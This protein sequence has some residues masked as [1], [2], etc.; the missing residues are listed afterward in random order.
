MKKKSG[1]LKIH[2]GKSPNFVLWKHKR[3]ALLL[4]LFLFSGLHSFSQD[5]AAK[6]HFGH[7]AGLD[8]MTNPPTIIPNVAIY[9]IEGSASISDAAGNTLF[10]TDG[11]TVYNK[12]NLIM[13]NGTGLFGN[14]STTQG[15]LI[16]K[17][18]GN[19][20]I[21]Y[22][23][24]Q[25]ELNG[26]KGLCYSLVDMSQGSGLG[27]VT[28]KNVLLHTPSCEKLAAVKHCNGVDVWVVSHDFGTNAFRSY[29]ITAAGINTTSPAIS[30]IGPV[31]THSITT[32]GQMKISPDGKKL[33]FVIHDI[34]SLNYNPTSRPVEIFDFDAATGTVSNQM[35]LQNFLGTYGCEFSPDGTKFYVSISQSFGSIFSP[36]PI[37]Y[38]FQWDLCA[39]SATAVAN[40]IY[41]IT[42]PSGTGKANQMQLARDGKIYIAKSF[43]NLATINAPNLAGAACDYSNSSVTFSLPAIGTLGL[44]N[45]MASL[46]KPA[47][48]PFTYST[49]CNNVNFFSPV[50][51][52]TVAS[53]CS[54][55]A[56]PIVSTS[57]NFGEPG[58]AA[59]NTSN[60]ANPTHSYSA[61]G[62]YTV[63]L[64]LNYA[65]G[66]D[67]ILLP[68]TIAG[69]SFSIAGLSTVCPKD[70]R[71]YTASGASSYSWSTGATTPTVALTTSV[72]TTYTVTAFGPGPNPC[73]MVTTFLV[74]V[75]KCTSIEPEEASG[76]FFKVYPNPTNGIL[77]IETDKEV[78]VVIENALGQI[79]LDSSYGSGSHKLDINTYKDGI[80]F[81][82]STS[83]SSSKIIRL[84]KT[85]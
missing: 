13:I 32:V 82:K 23:F 16:V 84:V 49:T 60:L 7:Y 36:T 59:T 76:T 77:N 72:T 73:K 2:T 50:P 57:W 22:I 37:F 64:S 21:Y 65:C 4:A 48:P 10:Y 28:T 54:F 40:S 78:K 19:S 6:W 35:S 79:L 58:S 17:Q 14:Q 18:P 51:Q 25:D 12:N 43:G 45:F 52:S 31:I 11:D 80:Y 46:L 85:E 20:S 75:S 5:Q 61:A 29:L 83:G 56:N 9:S 42:I 71:I 55:A 39:G 53:G 66:T 67:T 1:P 38:I 8:F 44:P 63:K 15:A 26:S 33:G 74:T 47:S 69:V 27:A 70:K 30:N 41:T 3:R 62:T 34:N 68:V 81:I 24:T